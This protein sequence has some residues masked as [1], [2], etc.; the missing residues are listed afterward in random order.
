MGDDPLTES[1]Q[2][3]PRES[4]L[5]IGTTTV[6]VFFRFEVRLGTFSSYDIV[7]AG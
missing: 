6:P 3:D 2:D 7:V 1:R 5:V 4:L